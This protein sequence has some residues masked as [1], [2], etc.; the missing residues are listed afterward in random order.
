MNLSESQRCWS[1]LGEHSESGAGV[2]GC[3][4]HD[5]R[6]F[7]S[8]PLVLIVHV[9]AD[10]CA[11]KRR[12]IHR[13]QRGRAER[14]PFPISNNTTDLRPPHRRTPAASGAPEHL[15]EPRL[16]GDDFL[17]TAAK[18]QKRF[19]LNPGSLYAADQPVMA[20][21]RQRAV[22]PSRAPFSF[23][24]LSSMVRS[25][26]SWAFRYRYSRLSLASR[27]SCNIKPRQL[28]P[29]DAGPIGSVPLSNDPAPNLSPFQQKML[30]VPTSQTRG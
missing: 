17:Q 24:F 15:C 3:G 4:D 12:Q 19:A 30:T 29:G 13:M 26:S 5:F 28:K 14:T 22:P 27:R 11:D 10:T 25:R 18:K 7:D 8:R 20:K 6:V 9:G 21:P 16:E 2:S 23:C 1:D